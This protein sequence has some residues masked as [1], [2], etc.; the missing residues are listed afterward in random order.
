MPDETRALLPGDGTQV[1]CP[2][3][4]SMASALELTSR[5][6]ARGR[7]HVQWGSAR[8]PP[9]EPG[10]VA[11][12][13]W[14][15][16]Y[17]GRGRGGFLFTKRLGVLAL[18]PP[19]RLPSS[20]PLEVGALNPERLEEFIDRYRS[21]DDPDIPAFM[22]GSHYS[23]A[24][25]VVLHYLVRLQPFADLHREMQVSGSSPSPS[26]ARGRRVRRTSF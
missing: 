22:Y 1:R 8:M 20:R 6:P 13:S 23:T 3:R 21:F 26:R 17:P 9:I 5:K 24:V 16:E 15:V 11:P 25:G 18:P 14:G 12:S 2:A 19:P 7:E 4:P 10:A